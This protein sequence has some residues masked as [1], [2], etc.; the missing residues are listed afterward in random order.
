MPIGLTSQEFWLEFNVGAFAQIILDIVYREVQEKKE[1]PIEG[2]K[3]H[4]NFVS[5]IALGPTN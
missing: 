1:N 5:K 3:N 2:K 4:V